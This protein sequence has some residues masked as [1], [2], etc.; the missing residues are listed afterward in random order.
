MDDETPCCMPSEML[1]FCPFDLCPNNDDVGEGVVARH[2]REAPAAQ[3]TTPSTTRDASQAPE[4]NLRPARWWESKA[5]T[6]AHRAAA[7]SSKAASSVQSAQAAAK[8]VQSAAAELQSIP[9][10]MW[11]REYALTQQRNNVCVFDAKY[12]LYVKTA[13]H[14]KRNTLNYEVYAD[15]LCTRLVSKAE[16]RLDD[17]LPHYGK[18]VKS[19]KRDGRFALVVCNNKD[20]VAPPFGNNNIAE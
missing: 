16:H 10:D 17:A 2:L 14:G 13:C 6:N 9:E 1:D 12:R 4:K 20:G 15:N 5:K 11:Y 19:S 7:K 3:T 18:C 8:S